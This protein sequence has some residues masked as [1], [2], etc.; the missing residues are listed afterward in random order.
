MARRK[1]KTTANKKRS[2]SRLKGKKAM[3]LA[4]EAIEAK[5][6]YNEI[7]NKIGKEVFV[8][9]AKPV[10]EAHPEIIA[11]RWKQYVPGFND[12]DPCLFRLCPSEILIE[13]DGEFLGEYSDDGDMPEEYHAA[14]NA[15]DE[16]LEELED[17]CEMVFDSNAEIT[18]HRDGK[19]EHDYYDCGY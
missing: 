5:K 17:A 4:K 9:L 8:E 19:I 16:A 18:I 3:N 12:G 15:F 14:S 13:P 2:G 11:V 1:K 10:F 6:K 7:L